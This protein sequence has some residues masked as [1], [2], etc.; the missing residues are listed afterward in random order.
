M[1][2]AQ[3]VQYT[4]ASVNHSQTHYLYTV[5]WYAHC[6]PVFHFRVLRGSAWSGGR[7]GPGFVG[8]GYAVVFVLNLL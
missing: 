2:V 8:V 5:Y 1:R 6:V 3:R 4:S 7:C